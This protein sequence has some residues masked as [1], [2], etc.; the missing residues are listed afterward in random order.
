VKA[1]RVSDIRHEDSKNDGQVLQQSTADKRV[2][3]GLPPSSKSGH[4]MTFR[5]LQ[6]KLAAIEQ[7]LD[8]FKGTSEK[9]AHDMVKSNQ[10]LVPSTGFEKRI[11]TQESLLSNELVKEQRMSSSFA[12]LP[13]STGKN[14]AAAPVK[15]M[16]AAETQ[17]RFGFE[18]KLKELQKDRD[19]P[20]VEKRDELPNYFQSN[21][22]SVEMAILSAGAA[23]ATSAGPNAGISNSKAA[24][25]R[26]SFGFTAQIASAKAQGPDAKLSSVISSNPFAHEPAREDKKK[27]LGTKQQNLKYPLSSLTFMSFLLNPKEWAKRDISNQEI[28]VLFRE[29]LEEFVEE[30]KLCAQF[31]RINPTPILSLP[32]LTLRKKYSHLR[33]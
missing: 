32:A 27:V 29:F 8:K 24:D 10:Y 26:K 21:L 11:D 30:F 4:H 1:P 31:S 2:K 16:K 15:G 22:R 23:N 20:V 17:E 9:V 5:S 13:S 12:M 18:S 6:E 25:S 7:K 3:G 33:K 19:A 28:V 14:Q